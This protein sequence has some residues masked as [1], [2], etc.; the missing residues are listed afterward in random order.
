MYNITFLNYGTIQENVPES[1]LRAIPTLSSHERL[2]ASQA[3]IGTTCMAKYFADQVLYRGDIFEQT[4]LGFKVKFPEYGNIE[5]VPLAY[6]YHLDKH[7]THERKTNPTKA[8]GKAPLRPKLP[9]KSITQPLISIPDNLKIVP[10]DSTAEKERKRKR[11]RAIK[12]LN[13]H[14]KIDNE[15]ET[16]KHGWKTFQAKKQRK[17]KGSMKKGPSIFQSPDTVD[18]KVGVTGS[19]Q[20]MTEF[21]D[22]RKKFQTRGEASMNEEGG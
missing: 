1:Q 8:S 16:K 17:V 9:T 18:G 3:S 11:I 4:S 12:S 13:R 21:V 7:E 22:T 10:S 14:K 2:D 6:L 5:E 20:G 19:G 15:R